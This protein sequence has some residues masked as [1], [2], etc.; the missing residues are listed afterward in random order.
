MGKTLL[1]TRPEHDAG[2]RYLSKWSEKIIDIA[3]DKGIN[4]IDLHREK[5]GRDRVIGTL[6]KYVNIKRTLMKY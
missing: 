2:T 3:K 5:A 1:I 6:E 4:V